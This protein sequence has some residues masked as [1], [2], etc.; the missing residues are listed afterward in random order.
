MKHH[1]LGSLVPGVCPVSAIS[2]RTQQKW[3]YDGQS[4]E[5]KQLLL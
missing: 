4:P 2:G 1:I 5:T 3:T